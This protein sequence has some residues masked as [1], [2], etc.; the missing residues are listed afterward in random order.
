MTTKYLGDSSTT[1]KITTGA[2][3]GIRNNMTNTKKGQTTQS[4]SN[5]T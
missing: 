4:K 5:P 2:I 1:K 3:K